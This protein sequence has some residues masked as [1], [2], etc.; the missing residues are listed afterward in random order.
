MYR[1]SGAELRSL[2]Q[3]LAEEGLAYLTHTHHPDFVERFGQVQ[4][5]MLTGMP[6]G[7]S[8]YDHHINLLKMKQH[9]IYHPYTD[10]EVLSDTFAKQLLT[11]ITIVRPR[12]DRLT[13]AATHPL[14]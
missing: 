3:H 12:A 6:R 13:H 7:F 4:G 1:P 10:Q 5:E 2:R 11:D 9:L 8:H 14:Q